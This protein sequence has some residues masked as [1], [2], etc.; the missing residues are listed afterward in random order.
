MKESR[1]RP[2]VKSLIWR[3]IALTVTY[4]TVWAFTGGIETSIMITLIANFAK[5][6]LYYT[7]ERVFQRIEWGILE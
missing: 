1:T 7:L 5:T 3:A 2:F 4:L 6:I